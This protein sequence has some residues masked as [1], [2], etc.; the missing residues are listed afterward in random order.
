VRV[1]DLWGW[2]IY[3]RGVY[4]LGEQVELVRRVLELGYS[5]CIIC[6][7]ATDPSDTTGTSHCFLRT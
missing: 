7:T 2:G 5:K 4:E 1:S 6:P 3:L